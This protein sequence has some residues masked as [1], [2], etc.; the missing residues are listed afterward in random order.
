[1]LAD[2][3]IEQA[4]ITHLQRAR[5]SQQ[6]AWVFKLFYAAFAASIVLTAIIPMVTGR[7]VAGPFFSPRSRMV[8]PTQTLL[9]AVDLILMA[10]I[11]GTQLVLIVQALLMTSD[12][13]ARERHNNTWDLLLLAGHDS[14]TIISGKWWA[15]QGY[16]FQKHRTLIF[17][18][19]GAVLWLGLALAGGSIS[20]LP[21]LIALA[22]A[23][24]LV[25]LF[26]I[27]DLALASSAGLVASV[28]AQ[29]G[30]SFVAAVGLYL[31]TAAVF[32]LSY[33]LI[34]AITGSFGRLW[35]VPP[36]LYRFSVPLALLPTPL[37]GGMLIGLRLQEPIPSNSW[38]FTLGLVTLNLIVL[39]VLT[40][41][42]LQLAGG[43]ARRRERQGG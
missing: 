9:L 1:V 34:D 13:I 40:W 3:P 10:L 11:V 26:T 2:D 17:L 16:L 30:V 27:L 19:A 36:L 43:L 21:D 31:S 37:D 22:L 35:T 38:L 33:P 20:N 39:S 29:R 23:P 18:R 24:A 42:L 32:G 5:S 12:A 8:N 28:L 14:G 41:L 6:G 4:E 25:L 15:V 7:S